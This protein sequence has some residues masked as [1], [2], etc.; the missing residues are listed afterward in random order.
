MAQPAASVAA[1][2]LEPA[3]QLPGTM[4][5]PYKL[6]EVLGEGGMGTVYVAEQEKPV[7]RKV[8]LKVIKPGM[9][10]REVIARFEAERQALA[11]MDHPNIAKVLDA[12][13]T[14]PL[15]PLSK[16][17]PGG[18][19]SPGDGVPHADRHPAAYAAGS[20]AGRP[21]FVMELVRG[22]PITDYCDQRQ[23]PPR[24]RLKLFI[25]VCQ[26]VQHAHQKGIIHRDLK[27][28]NIL[29]AQHDPGAPGVPKV[30]DFG[31]A[32]ATSQRLTDQSLYTRFAQLLGTPLYMSP[33]QAELNAL[34]V[35]TRSDV[36][37]LGVLLYELLTGATPFDKETFAKVGFDEMRRIIREDEPPRPS[38]RVSTLAAQAAVSTLA[39][40]TQRQQVDERQRSRALRGELDWIVMKA[41]EKDRTRRYESAS[42][43]AADVQRFLDD[44][45]VQA[46]PPS[47]VYRVRKLARRN[48]AALV[49]V[50]LVT[51]A[52][53]AGTAV[54]VWQAVEANTAR[55]LADDNATLAG[56]RLVLADDRLKLADERL[57][58]ET[59]ARED[60]T[61]ERER[62]EENL[63]KS[64][65]V[66]DRMLTQV[67]DKR[68]A[69]IPGVEPVRKQILEDALEFYEQFLEQ[70]T[71]DPAL[72]FEVAKAC[73]RA[74]QLQDHVEQQGKA[75]AS[76]LK[77]IEI[78]D[79]LAAQ[80]PSEPQY[81]D[82]LADASLKLGATVNAP[83]GARVNPT[84]ALTRGLSACERLQ[85]MAPNAAEPAY[86][87][88]Q[89]QCE[90]ADWRTGIV[91]RGI[92]V[93]PSSWPRSPYANSR[94]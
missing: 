12:G 82:L 63:K 85:R 74:G 92:E 57:A 9:D 70:R 77:A 67:G 86:K 59:K 26:A 80:H 53:L 5:G 39:T 54:S 43:F 58:N 3:Y 62:A 32:K 78:A 30:I 15:P 49:T 17:G 81:L 90:L 47:A 34:D 65:E 55:N 45:P 64:L 2:I 35:D 69:R 37:S 89:L 68:L 29:V 13:T 1:T 31:I 72:Q 18:V 14:S 44:E 33:E 60:A 50:S 20:P 66:V 73:L 56:E 16:G 51:V 48:R 75:A 27:P 46:C 94:N 79:L 7:R 38:Q 25:Q 19:A 52:L 91:P 41:L 4:I 22:I 87:A 93:R 21:Y 40:V 71:D 28:S 76:F 10:T 42:A 36:Y 61:R 84:E 88:A 11:L 8:A 24:E 23:L 83:S 6:R